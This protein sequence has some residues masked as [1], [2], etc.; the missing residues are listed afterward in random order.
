MKKFIITAL[1]VFLMITS[2]LSFVSAEMTTEE[3]ILNTTNQYEEENRIGEEVRA[4]KSGNYNITFDDGYNGYC[5][6][7]GDASAEYNDLF[8]VQ[9]TSLAV[10]HKTGEQVGNYI[11]TYFVEFYDIAVKDKYKTQEII[12]AFTDDFAFYDQDFL[13]EIK[14]KSMEK[15]I[16]DHG[17]IKKI[18]DTAGVIF[19][20]E[21][22]DSHKY[23]SQ[24]FFGYKIT[25]FTMNYGG[26][27]ES[28]A[29]NSMPENSTNQENT[30]I[31]ENNTTKQENITI[32]ENST[33]QENTTIPENNTTKQEN[34]MTNITV[35]ADESEDEIIPSS[36]NKKEINQNLEKHATG[37]G[38]FLIALLLIVACG[39]II[40]LKRD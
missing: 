37:N 16:P 10:N 19:D 9:N 4:T 1:T 27:G 23:N 31:P 6:N 39:T 14:E 7:L 40:R 30:T 12:W 2:S 18:N 24:N 13:N 25:Q 17:A 28:E 20:F 21:V 3:N 38:I 29:E 8:T 32:S 36:E 22:L 35:P 26:L 33:N 15:I 11:K 34:N 5:I